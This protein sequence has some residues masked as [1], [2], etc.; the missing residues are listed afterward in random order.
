[1]NYICIYVIIYLMFN[2]QTHMPKCYE[3]YIIWETQ[4]ICKEQNKCQVIGRWGMDVFKIG[5]GSKDGGNEKGR[6]KEW[7]KEFRC[8][9]CL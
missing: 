4:N 3:A 5:R 8:V 1:M 9:M 7:K 2:Y 6:G